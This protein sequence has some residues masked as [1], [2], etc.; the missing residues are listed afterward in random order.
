MINILNNYEAHFGINYLFRM[1]LS[2][3]YLNS[4]IALLV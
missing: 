2:F 4:H 1:I 3:K